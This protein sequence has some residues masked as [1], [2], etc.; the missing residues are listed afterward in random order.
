MYV[1]ERK[2]MSQFLA[3]EAGEIQGQEAAVMYIPGVLQDKGFRAEQR[4]RR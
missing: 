2:V 1:K 4:L 3:M